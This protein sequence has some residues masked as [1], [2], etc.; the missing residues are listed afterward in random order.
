V[1]QLRRWSGVKPD[2]NLLALDLADVKRKLELMPVI[3]SASV[4]RILPH[5]LH[6]RVVE[7]EAI[8]QVNFIRPSASGRVELAALLLDADGW[9][10]LPLAPSQRVVSANQAA[11]QLPIIAGINPSDLQPGRRLEAPQ[12]RAA[13]Q[14][15]SCFE[16]SSLAGLVD[17]KRIDVSDPEVLT[18][19]TG[20]GSE[21][22]FGLS[23]LERQLRRWREIF[24]W[25]QKQGKAIAALD[26][27]VTN[28]IPARWLEASAVPQTT[29]KLPKS[30][31]HQKTTCLSH[32][33]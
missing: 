20:Q 7:R 33:Q 27:A 17:L 3:E 2:A 19:S 1:D 12:V 14:L 21:I 22:V 29:P 26:L 24:D 32:P 5:T 23:D 31:T 9:V 28:N 6:I 4:E 18:V 15:L 13:L 11:E 25:G 30:F 16:R 10:M 8:A